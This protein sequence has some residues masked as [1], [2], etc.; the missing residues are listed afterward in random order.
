[1]TTT[2]PAIHVPDVERLLAA[3]DLFARL[4][5]AVAL[6]DDTL[7]IRVER[8]GINAQ[9]VRSAMPAGRRYF[10]LCDIART[11]L[12]S[13]ITTVTYEPPV[14]DAEYWGAFHVTGEWAGLPVDIWTGLSLD[15]ARTLSL[16]RCADCGHVDHDGDD[17]LAS[18]I[19]ADGVAD[20]RC[21]CGP[22]ADEPTVGERDTDPGAVVALSDDAEDAER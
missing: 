6:P 21:L 1:M 7:A 13:T 16:A 19:T 3:A 8:N 17:C 10:T 2:H 22:L 14:A 5:A 20:A 4:H 15:D 9:L 18:M 11:V 12:N